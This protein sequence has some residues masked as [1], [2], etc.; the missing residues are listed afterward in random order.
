MFS[1]RSGINSVG[2]ARRQALVDWRVEAHRRR[3]VERDVDGGRDVGLVVATSRRRLRR[4]ARS[5]GGFRVR[6]YGSGNGGDRRRLPSPR[7]D[8][9]RYTGVQEV[10]EQAPED[11]LNKDAGDAR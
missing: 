4:R 5:K 8:E 2:E 1:S 9:D 6:S 3:R 11:D 7:A 10:E